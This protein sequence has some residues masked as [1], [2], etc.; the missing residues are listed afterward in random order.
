M[1]LLKKTYVWSV[2]LEPMLYL[3]WMDYIYGSNLGVSR[4]LQ[5]VVIFCLLFRFIINGFQIIRVSIFDPM[6]KYY[7]YFMFFS[8]FSALFGIFYGSYTLPLT[9]THETMFMSVFRPITEYIINIYYVV[10]FVILARFMLND[11]QIIDYFFKVFSVI[12]YFSLV[13][14]LFDLILMINIEEYDG[15]DRQIRG[16]VGVGQR[17]HGYAGEPRDA[18]VYLW[19]GIGVL[20]LKDIWKGETKLT[21]KRLL[22]IFIAMVMTQSASGIFGMIF[23]CVLIFMI[24]LLLIG[25]VIS[26]N[27]SGRLGNYSYGFATLYYDLINGV[28]IRGNIAEAL[29]NIYPVLDRLLEIMNLNFLPLIFGTGLGTSSV[30]NN[31]YMMEVNNVINPNANIVRMIYDVGI[32]GSLLLI[33]SFIYP[34]ERLSINREMSLKLIFLMLF[35]LGAYFGHRS[36]APFLFLGILIVAIE[37]KFPTSLNK[38]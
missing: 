32:I 29:S 13:V 33:K 16:T 10:Y 15:I 6:Y 37:N 30:A 18:F 27:T 21:K 12:F 14:G 20:Y 17:F 11:S 9:S 8:V 19:L 2:C 1:N 35:I 4:S 28:E 34:I 3:L 23:S 24:I 5:L 38:N 7:F 22:L 26:V 31:I 36:V 25:V